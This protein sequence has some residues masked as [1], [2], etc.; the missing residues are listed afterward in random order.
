MGGNASQ[1]PLFKLQLLLAEHWA[2]LVQ[3]MTFFGFGPQPPR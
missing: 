2:S 3:P 1:M